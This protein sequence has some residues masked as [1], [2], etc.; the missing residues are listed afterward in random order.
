MANEL[1]PAGRGYLYIKTEST[2]ATDPT[3]GATNVIYVEDFS[4][5]YSQDEIPRTGITHC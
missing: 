4:W 3:A 1:L 5:S 2:Y